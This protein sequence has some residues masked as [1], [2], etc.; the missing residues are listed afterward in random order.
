MTDAS[1]PAPPPDRG[2]GFGVV[3]GLDPAL[4]APLAVEVAAFGY[5]AFWIND[6]GRPDADGLAGLALVDRVAP[7]LDLGVGVLPLDR[8]AIPDIAR[9]V[10]ELGLPLDRLRLGVGSGGEMGRPLGLVRDGVAALREQLPGARIF[11][12]AL[13]PKMSR[14]AG[15]VAD[16]VL[17]N[18][19]VPERLALVSGL[20][21]EGARVAGRPPVDRWTYVR[22]AVGADARDRIEAEGR[23]YARSG[24]YAAAFEAMGV[25]F[26]E[27][28]VA[29][30]DLRDQLST[31]RAVVD[32]VVVRALPPSWTLEAALA[33][34]RAAAPERAP[35]S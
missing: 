8:R 30:D 11:V 1:S 35:G 23:R 4:L 10:R 31:Y 22:A 25:P 9:E 5:G 14:L 15:E 2:L 13:G 3:A 16:G 34:A 28:G 18:W 12:S 21:E 20:V 33:I 27:V 32:G 19:A 17:F 24:G 6:S 7:T 29:G 26:A